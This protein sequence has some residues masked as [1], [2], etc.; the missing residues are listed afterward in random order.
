MVKC[1]GINGWKANA[2]PR[3]W[4]VWENTPLLPGGEWAQLELTDK[5]A[6]ENSQQPKT[7]QKK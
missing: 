7:V 2:R 1:P 5:S 4:T 6:P 3:G